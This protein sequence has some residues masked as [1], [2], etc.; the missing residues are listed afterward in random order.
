M[1]QRALQ[2]LPVTGHVAV[3]AR[4]QAHHVDP[5]MSASN[6]P[7]T[8]RAPAGSAMMPRSDTDRDV[9]RRTVDGGERK[10]C[11]RRRLARHRSACSLIAV[12]EPVD[13]VQ[14]HR[15][16]CY[17]RAIMAVYHGS[18]PSSRC[19]SSARPGGDPRDAAAA[20]HRDHHQVRLV[21][22][23]GADGY[24]ALAGDMR[25]SSN[26]GTSVARC[27]PRPQ[28][29]RRRSQ[30]IVDPLHDQVDELPAVVAGLVT[31]AWGFCRYV[32]PAVHTQ[33]ATF[34][35]EVCACCRGRTPR[36][37]PVLIGQLH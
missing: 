28:A 10:P 14:R 36:P 4:N 17:E 13:M 15:L 21:L 26:G 7:A 32:D 23:S 3:A 35:R 29:G 33:T 31:L 18:T 19:W 11:R 34:I 20:T 16:A 9:A 1:D 5:P 8:D 22:E 30:I 2:H 6:R 37:R 27:A 12:D 25:R 24:R